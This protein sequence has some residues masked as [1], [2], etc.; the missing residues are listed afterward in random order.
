[1]EVIYEK[2]AEFL[3]KFTGLDVSR[4]K[5]Y[6]MALE[7]GR[8]IE[9]WEEKKREQ[10]FGKGESVEGGPERVPKVLYIQVDGTGG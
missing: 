7:E 2:T 5:I 6:E 8:R 3:K 10:V 4:Q 9:G 1:M